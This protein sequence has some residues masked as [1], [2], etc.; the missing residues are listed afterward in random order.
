MR[1]GDDVLVVKPHVGVD[2]PLFI[3]AKEP[4]EVTEKG[5]VVLLGNL[6]GGGL[7]HT[8]CISG[9]LHQLE[10]KVPAIPQG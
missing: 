10:M 8:Q 5:T 3:V 7:E 1:N 4:G 2:H 9:A 6:G